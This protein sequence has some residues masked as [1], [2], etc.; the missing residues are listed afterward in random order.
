MYTTLISNRLYS[1][2]GVHNSIHIITAMNTLS[3]G[4]DPSADEYYVG[5]GEHGPVCAWQSV[6]SHRGS[7]Q[8]RKR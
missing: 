7:S 1:F 3:E 6:Y 8:L 4:F 2:S 5:S